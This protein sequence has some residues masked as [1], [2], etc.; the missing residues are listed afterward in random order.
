M[1]PS[2]SAGD[3]KILFIAGGAFL[4]LV[5][6]GFLFAPTHNIE[7]DAATTYST[8]SAGA[9]AAFLLLQETGYRVERWQHSPK[10]LKPDKHTVLIVADPA[11]IP[12][13]KQNPEIERFVSGGGRLITTGLYGARL[14][15]EDSSEYNPMPKNPWSEF[16]AL[17]PSAITRAA[18]NIKLAPVA[19]VTD[20]ATYAPSM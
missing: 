20:S 4:V 17:A 15:P 9:K 19:R 11:L 6:L 12:N 16:K 18:P 8:S 1:P 5:V 10:A 7:S 2:L 3:R 14:L 13:P